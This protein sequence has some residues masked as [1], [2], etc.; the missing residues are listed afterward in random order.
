MGLPDIVA[1]IVALAA[2]VSACVAIR[3]SNAAIKSSNTAVEMNGKA[4]SERYGALTESVGNINRKLDDGTSG[5]GALKDGMNS[6]RN[7]CSE[8]STAISAQVSQNVK[9]I[10]NM[11]PRG[12]KK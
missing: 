12:K 2:L 3:A 11:Q 1:L 10:E 4:Q 6:M 7:H 9:D 5:L 8:V